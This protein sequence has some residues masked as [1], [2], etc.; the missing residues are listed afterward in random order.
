MNKM[1]LYYDKGKYGHPRNWVLLDKKR[2]RV[3][4]IFG[5]KKPA[6]KEILAEERRVQWFK[7]YKRK[8]IN[9][10][11]NRPSAKKPRKQ[12]RRI[13]KK[14]YRKIYKKA[15]KKGYK[16]PHM[17][18]ERGPIVPD[19]V[20]IPEN[21]EFE[22]FVT[23]LKDPDDEGYFVGIDDDA[24]L[25][26]KKK[27]FA[28]EL[29][30]IHSFET[31]GTAGK[32]K[33]VDKIAADI[34]DMPLEEFKGKQSIIGKSKMNFSERHLDSMNR[35]AQE[36]RG[37]NDEIDELEAEQVRFEETE[38]SEKSQADF[39]RLIQIN[40]KLGSLYRELENKKTAYEE[41]KELLENL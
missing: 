2:K 1:V 41:E 39:N 18:A 11:E 20:N 15:K 34:L 6:R 22:G 37:I 17:S 13:I 23:K 28:H 29:G 21:F 40:T 36:I 35:L 38:P 19:E 5:K 3:L 30:H 33:K 25:K 7:T 27:T 9:V 14:M 24:L 10:R 12:H 4:R 16:L 31:K 32:E 8:A 26:E